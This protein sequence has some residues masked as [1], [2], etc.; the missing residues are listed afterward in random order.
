[1]HQSILEQ[2]KK[3]QKKSVPK[4][5]AG[6]TV[7]VHERIKEGEKF[8]TQVFEGLIIRVHNQ[9]NI[10]T[11]FT[12]RKIVDGIGV[13]KIFLLHSPTIEKIEIIRE[14]KI[15]QANIYYIRELQ[16]K[17]ARL[18]SKFVTNVDEEVLKEDK[19]EEPVAEQQVEEKA[20][21]AT[22]EQAEAPAQE[23]AKDEIKE[24]AKAEEAKE[25]KPAEEAKSEEKA[26]A[27]AAE[28]KEEVKEET[29][30]EEVKEEK[31]A[32]EAKEEK[33]EEKA[34]ADTAEKKD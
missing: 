18:K 7:R 31:P 25:E 28:T 5:K 15:K 23:E 13:E 3:Y 16:G 1:M 30:T 2:D 33:P 12:V 9:K 34:E 17:A 21:A 11:T 32:E 4:L 20:E 6:L 22:E 24:E 19:P 27:P 29:K 14:A 8:R 26:E 10:S